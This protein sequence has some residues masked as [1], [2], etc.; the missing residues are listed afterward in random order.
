MKGDRE[1]AISFEPGFTLA[2]VVVVSAIVA[3]LASVAIPVY[4]GYLTSQRQSAVDNLA[5]TA[6]IAANSYLRR[7]NQIPTVAKL[8]LFLPVPGKYQITISSAD[9]TVIVK[10]A[11]DLSIADTVFFK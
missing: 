5:S 9:T 11:S 2:E 1:K 6:A 10:D 3:I 4:T 8:G 7:Y